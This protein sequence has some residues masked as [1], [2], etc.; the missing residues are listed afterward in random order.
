MCI[1]VFVVV[2]SAL[3]IYVMCVVSEVVV[4][5]LLCFGGFNACCGV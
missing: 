4:N 2:V 1:Y 5:V 3:L